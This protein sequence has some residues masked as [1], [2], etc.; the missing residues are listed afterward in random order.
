[1][2]QLNCKW[3]SRDMTTRNNTKWEVGVPKELPE[4]NNLKLCE[5]GL[6]HYFPHPLLAVM[7]KASS[8]CVNYSKLYEV[9]PEG[10][11]VEGWNKRGSTKLTLVKELEIPQITDVQLIAFG[12][13]CALEVC[14]QK[15]FV[16]W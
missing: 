11:I 2:S 3:V 14:K 1:M 7:F 10:K 4:R 16:S 9:K 12:V 8:K 13:L 15:D 5:E 6:F